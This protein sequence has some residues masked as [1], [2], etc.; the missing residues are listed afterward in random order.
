MSRD[1]QPRHDPPDDVL[2]RRARRGDDEAFAE[3][4][5]RWQRP[6][7]ARALAAVGRVEEADD[8]VQETFLRAWRNLRGLRNPGGFGAFCLTTLRRLVVDRSRRGDVPAEAGDEAAAAAPDPAPG[9]EDELLAAEL[10]RAVREELA[11]LPPGRQR[12]VFRLRFG[13]GLPLREIA[14]RLGLHAGTVKVHL[15]RGTRQLR[16]RLVGTR[17]APGA[18]G[19]T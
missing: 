12:E 19:R 9:P 16:A 11:A 6:L 2:V 4:V 18:P 1:G 8:L 14:S 7:M 17:P 5:R 3:L 15:F 10:R 13:E